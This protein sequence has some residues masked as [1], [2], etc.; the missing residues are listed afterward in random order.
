MWYPALR[1]Q[2]AQGSG[3]AILAGRG[4]APVRRPSRGRRT[5][6][7]SAAHAGPPAPPRASMMWPT[8]PQPQPFRQAIQSAWFAARRVYFTCAY[9]GRS[10][11]PH[12]QA[13]LALGQGDASMLLRRSTTVQCSSAAHQPKPHSLP[14]LQRGEGPRQT[15]LRALRLEHALQHN[16]HPPIAGV[17]SSS[18]EPTLA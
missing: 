10:H 18:C 13:R 2:Q 14:H 1:G 17:T 4:C 5:D 16:G 7:S 12:V 3:G 8:Q 11:A 15:F 9:T 6:A